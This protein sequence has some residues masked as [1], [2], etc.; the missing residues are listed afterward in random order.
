MPRRRRRLYDDGGVPQLPPELIQRIAL[1]VPETANFFCYL[2]AFHKVPLL[3]GNLWY[4]WHLSQEQPD[5]DDLWPELHV[6][7]L[8]S[9]NLA[10]IQAMAHVFSVIHFHETFDVGLLQHCVSST[11]AFTIR[12]T[13]TDADHILEPV[14]EWYAQLSRLPI[15]ELRWERA[16]DPDHR[17]IAALVSSM[18]SMPSLHCLDLRLPPS[19]IEPL[20]R[21]VATSSLVDL[22]LQ[23]QALQTDSGVSL[24]PTDIQS[25]THWLQ[26][27]PVHNLYLEG[28]SAWHVPETIMAQFYTAL[29]SNQ[30]LWALG[31]HSVPLPHLDDFTFASPVHVHSLVLQGCDLGPADMKALSQGLHLSSVTELDLTGNPL[32]YTGIDALASVLPHTKIE[33]L[34]LMLTQ[35]GDRGCAALAVALPLSCVVD[36][37]LSMN[38]ISSVGA[39]DLA[40]GLSQSATLSTLQLQSNCISSTGAAMLVRTLG[41]RPVPT[42]LDLRNNTWDHDQA[43]REMVDQLPCTHVVALHTNSSTDCSLD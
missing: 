33:T 22:S 37:D 7:S 2:E 6:H 25:L 12:L 21:Y 20:L 43:L 23:A 8:T 34:K 14:E 5:L 35:T 15:S 31:L 19:M 32:E 41:S 18:P 11:C 30:S 9:S 42:T 36:L 26:S 4:L 24:T 38:L 39:T 16:S 1:Y 13:T 17:H 28:W 29:W 3:L 40:H 27:Q 10:S